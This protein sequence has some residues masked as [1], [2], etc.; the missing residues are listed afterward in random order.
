MKIFDC[1]IWEIYNFNELKKELKNNN[2]IFTSNSDTEIILAAYD[3]WGQDCQK[4]L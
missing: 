4:N 1:L 2:Y 3:L